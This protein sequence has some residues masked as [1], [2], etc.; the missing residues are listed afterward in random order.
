MSLFG[1]T[2]V[3]TRDA[4]QAK[5][6]LNLLK[7]NQAGVFLFPTIKL[8]NA[9]NPEL[10]YKVTS[11]ISEFEWIIFTSAIAIRFFM[12]HANTADLK[13][14]KITCVGKKT[15]EELSK[16]NLSATLIPAIPTSVNLLIEMKTL[17]LKNKQILIPCSSLSNN[18]LKEGFENE[19]AIVEQ[20]VVYKNEPFDNPDKIHLVEKIENKKIDCITFFSPSAVNS[21]TKII[22]DDILTLIKDQNIPIAVIG[23]TTE[24]A[25][26][27]S[28][29]NPTIKPV[30][31]DNQSMVEAL[32]NFLIS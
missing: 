11:R 5:P 19:G 4:S 22:D 25:V 30:E 15:A 6:F 29:L 26:I 24:K 14:L 8:T 3:V 12:E 16:Y 31:S 21:F 7:E 18:D 32:I 20:V 23:P 17:D 13:D 28:G 9:D 1:K 27:N 10:I 2:I